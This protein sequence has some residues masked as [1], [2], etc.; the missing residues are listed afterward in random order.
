MRTQW[1]LMGKHRQ[2]ESR[3]KPQPA[4]D[5]RGLPRE[6]LSALGPE[7][8]QGLILPGGGGRGEEEKRE[9]KGRRGRKRRGQSVQRLPLLSLFHSLPGEEAS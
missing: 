7:G 4:W 2:C 8:E 9:E 3:G 6:R 5:V 1:D